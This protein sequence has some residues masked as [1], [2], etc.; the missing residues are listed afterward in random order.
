MKSNRYVLLNTASI[1]PFL[2]SPRR[3]IVVPV[4]QRKSTAAGNSLV[5][6]I[7]V[8]YSF[9]L[10]FIAPYT[11]YFLFRLSFVFVSMEKEFLSLCGERLYFLTPVPYPP[12]FQDTKGVG[13][14]AYR[15]YFLEEV[16]VKQPQCLRQYYSSILREDDRVVLQQYSILISTTSMVSLST[17]RQGQFII[18]I[19]DDVYRMHKN[20]I[21]LVNP[22]LIKSL[23]W[24]YYYDHHPNCWNLEN[25]NHPPPILGYY[26]TRTEKT[27]F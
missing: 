14:K 3:G 1:S 25:N 21:I 20:N 16:V 17:I 23:L 8:A 9:A 4:M 22:F 18:I 24:I 2:S 10:T 19:Y 11:P 26:C 7:F 5:N 15:L 13:G 12:Y 27:L 6:I